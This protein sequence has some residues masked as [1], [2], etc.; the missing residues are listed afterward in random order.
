MLADGKLQ[1]STI[2]TSSPTEIGGSPICW[3]KGGL[4]TTHWM[5]NGIAKGEGVRVSKIFHQASRNWMARLM[6]SFMG[7]DAFARK[8]SVSMLSLCF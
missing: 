2:T 3:T 7:T 4:Q 6:G 8:T 5:F 1:T